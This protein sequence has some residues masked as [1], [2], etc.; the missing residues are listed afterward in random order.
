M[1]GRP[2]FGAVVGEAIVDLRPRLPRF[3]SLIDIFRAQALE[4][5][6]AASKGVRTDGIANMCQRNARS[7]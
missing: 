1:R 7:T 2:S 3:H 5:A 4:Q 6:K